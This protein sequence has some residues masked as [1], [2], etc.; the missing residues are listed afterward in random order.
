[1]SRPFPP[2]GSSSGTP[3]TRVNGKIRAREVR[4]LGPDGQQIGILSLNDALAK[5]RHLGV[6]LVEIAPTAQPPVCKLV[7]YG[8][9]RYEQAKRDKESKKHQHANKV[10]EVQLSANIDPHDFGVKFAHAVQFLCEDM[11]VKISLRFRGREMAHT[12]FG[13]QVVNKF[14][15][16]SAPW[17]HP[18]APPKLLGKSINVMLSP[19]PRNKRAKNPNADAEAGAAGSPHGAPKADTPAAKVE[20]RPVAAPSPASPKR[21]AAQS[22]A[23]FANNPFSSLDLDKLQHGEASGVS[24][25]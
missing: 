14:I 23:G 10:K 22:K 12:E 1:M 9:Y 18:D 3:F 13:F 19:L 4:V 25:A 15:N 5:A 20:L 8:K 17:A 24:A 6:D 11:K 2:R 7:D 21:A 16:D